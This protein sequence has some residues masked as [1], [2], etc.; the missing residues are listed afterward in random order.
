MAQAKRRKRRYKDFVIS[1]PSDGLEVNT[2]NGA[3]FVSR[4]QSLISIF[5]ADNVVIELDE[6]MNGSRF[7]RVSIVREVKRVNR[8][9]TARINR[10]KD[11]IQGR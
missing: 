4:R 2:I 1:D 9:K 8:S 5:D 11:R 7:H 3:R 10:Y 6:L